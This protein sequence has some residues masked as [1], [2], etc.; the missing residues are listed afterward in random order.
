[1]QKP[2]RRPNQGFTLWELLVALSLIV[3]LLA[4]LLPILGGPKNKSCA[5]NLK[6]I[7][8][9]LM[10]YTR[11]ND[12][13]FPPVV[14]ELRL[15]EGKTYEQQWGIT[16][17]S[18]DSGK[19]VTIPGIISGYVKDEDVFL[20]PS[21]IKPISGLSYLYNDLAAKE[22]VADISSVASTVVFA[23]GDDRLRNFGHA[24]SQSS[25]GSP[26]I[27]IRGAAVGSAVKRH[28]NGGNYGFTDGHVKWLKPEA[29]FYPLRNS[30]SSCHREAKTGTLLGPDPA[31]ITQKG[32]TFRGRLYSATFHL[33]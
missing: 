13:R 8:I 4:I 15:A 22:S 9:A 1:M 19:Q 31:S 16:T 33:R 21:I 11:D 5:T 26:A 17:T 25:T 24:R 14:G 28:G 20:C 27:L 29:V 10:E 7:G 18:E 3:A 2:S 32:M 6:K 23:E 12:D 30:G